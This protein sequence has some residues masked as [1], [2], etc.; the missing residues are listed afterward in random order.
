MSDLVYIVFLSPAEEERGFDLLIRRA[1]LQ[2]YANGVYGVDRAASS[3]LIGE[4]VGY[5]EATREEIA[6]NVPGR[7]V[8]DPAAAHV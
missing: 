1:P 6:S 7:P 4:R 5:R 2:A 3:L 8:R